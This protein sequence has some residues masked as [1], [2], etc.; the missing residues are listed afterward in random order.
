MKPPTSL[1]KLVRLGV[2]KEY[3]RDG[4]VKLSVDQIVSVSSKFIAFLPTS[5]ID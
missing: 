2:E 5:L 3:P 4:S 1:K